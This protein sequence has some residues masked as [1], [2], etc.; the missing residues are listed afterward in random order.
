MQNEIDAAHWNTIKIELQTM[1]PFLTES[2]LLWR[3]GNTKID[4]LKD[5][6]TRIGI[7]WKVLDEIIAKI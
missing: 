4:L 6:S 5:L 7:S 3:D 2:D 1:Y